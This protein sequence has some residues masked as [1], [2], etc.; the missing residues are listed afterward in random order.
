MEEKNMNMAGNSGEYIYY[1][2]M[3]LTNE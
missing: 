3:L 2:C 1:A